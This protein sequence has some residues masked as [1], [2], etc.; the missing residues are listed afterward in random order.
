MDPTADPLL[1][2][3][4]LIEALR[5]DKLIA[6]DVVS[7]V[8][9]RMHLAL[10]AFFLA[11]RSR[12]LRFLLDLAEQ[13]LRGKSVVACS[14]ET[15]AAAERIYR[16]VSSTPDP[17][18]TFQALGLVMRAAQ[19]VG[20]GQGLSLGAMTFET[21]KRLSR[22]S[23]KDG[24]PKSIATR[25]ANRD[26]TWEDNGLE[27]ATKYIAGRPCYDDLAL[28]RHI[29]KKLDGKGPTTDRGMKNAIAR[30]RNH[31]Q[32]PASEAKGPELPTKQQTNRN[33]GSDP[34]FAV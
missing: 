27:A 26:K 1:E 6:N 9:R 4:L 34:P 21:E 25:Q 11:E 30:W 18:A 19:G 23:G 17:A 20:V 5:G 29:I 14:N 15:N 28:A 22:M 16:L 7:A 31:L 32:I 33:S 3:K 12:D 13:E 24:V 8:R 10:A 2:I